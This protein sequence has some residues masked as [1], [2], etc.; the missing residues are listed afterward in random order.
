MVGFE[1]HLD[2]GVVV[3]FAELSGCLFRQ[4]HGRQIVV[5][6]QELAQSVS[7]QSRLLFERTQLFGVHQEIAQLVS[8]NVLFELHEHAH[9]RVADAFEFFL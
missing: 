7:D 4:I 1:Q 6:V 3:F 5:C 2:F 9:D 8:V